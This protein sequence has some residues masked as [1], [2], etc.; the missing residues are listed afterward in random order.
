MLPTIIG[1]GVDADADVE[2]RQ[3]LARASAFE[4]LQLLEEA[5]R[6]A[7][8]AQRVVL[9]IDRRA[10]EGHQRVADVLVERAALLE[11]DAGS[12]A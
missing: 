1:P 7:A 4:L 12:S 9:L 8:G 3:V 5:Q 10:P 11:D 6:G 2:L